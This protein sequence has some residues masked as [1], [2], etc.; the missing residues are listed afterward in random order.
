MAHSRQKIGISTTREPLF[1]PF[2]LNYRAK[3]TTTSFKY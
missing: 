3:E 2:F 1:K